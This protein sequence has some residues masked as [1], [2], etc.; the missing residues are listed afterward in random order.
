[1]FW[2]HKMFLLALQVQRVVARVVSAAV[3]LVE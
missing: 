1:M 3:P 2:Q